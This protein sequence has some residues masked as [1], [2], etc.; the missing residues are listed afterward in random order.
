MLVPKDFDEQDLIPHFERF[1]PIYQFRLLIDYDNNCR[2]FA[3]IIFFW[4]KS[5]I[6]CLDLMGYFII[7]PGVMLDVERSQERSHLLALNVPSTMTEEKIEEGFRGV[8]GKLTRCYVRRS[9]KTPKDEADQHCNAI[10]KFPDHTA[11]LNAKRLGGQGSVH[12]WNRNIKI[13]WAKSEEVEKLM[14][15][16]EDVKHVFVHNMPSTLDPDDFGALMCDFVCPQEIVQIRPMRSDWLIQFT[17]TQ[18][19]FTISNL[20]NS[21]ILENQIVFTELA[22]HERLKIIDNFADFDF[23]LRCLCLANY[24]DPPIFIYGRIIP[25]TKTQLCAVIIKNNRRNLYCTFFLE[26]MYDA[27]VEIHARVCEALVL[28]IMEMKNLPKK[29]IV[30]KCTS[31][32]ALIVGAIANLQHPRLNPSS[33][34][35][36]ESIFLYLDEIFAL[37]KMCFQLVLS[38]KLEEIHNEYKMI[39]KQRNICHQTICGIESDGNLLGCI[40]PVYRHGKPLKYQLNSRHM[41]LAMCDRRSQSNVQ[42]RNFPEIFNVKNFCVKPGI[43]FKEEKFE[44]IPVAHSQD[45]NVHFA[46]RPCIEFNLV[47]T[48][49]PLFKLLTM[50]QADHN[51]Y[52]QMQNQPTPSVVSHETH[53][54]RSSNDSFYCFEELMKTLPN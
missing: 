21:R 54:Q 6:E 20:F 41:I 50:P 17:N 8:Y 18:A 4:E 7:V 48:Y 46:F 28:I 11:A 24:W 12:L 37:S 33:V 49:N 30:I 53:M 3:Y 15:T 27:L 23:E 36:H 16:D 40:D 39:L 26:I 10:L 29:N 2:G 9:E 35:T 44:L 31:S 22:T 47:D 13:L 42:F 52:H 25:G 5:A 51:R 34:A 45:Q 32:Y 1:G 19:A 43:R 38:E 14:T